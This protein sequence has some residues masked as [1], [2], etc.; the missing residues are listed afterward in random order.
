MTAIDQAGVGSKTI[1][2]TTAL[3]VERIT[4]YMKHNI[5]DV[6]LK[7]YTLAEIAQLTRQSRSR[8]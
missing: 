6:L 3:N 7:P 5:K 1:I 4:A 2:L 8:L